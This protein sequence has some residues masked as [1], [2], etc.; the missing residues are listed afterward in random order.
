MDRGDCDVRKKRKRKNVNRILRGSAFA[1]TFSLAVFG[2]FLFQRVGF[3][4]DE[5]QEKIDLSQL[6]ET[7]TAEGVQEKMT[8]ESISDAAEASLN[9]VKNSEIFAFTEDEIDEKK[10]TEQD[11]ETK[12]TIP[13]QN[14]EVEAIVSHSEEESIAEETDQTNLSGESEKTSG[15]DFEEQGESTELEET[16]AAAA[17]H[18]LNFGESLNWPIEGNILLDYNM[19]NA[20]YFQTL[21]QYRCNPAVILEGTEG[22]SVLSAAD[23]MVKSV[24][25]SEETGVTLSVDL[26][27]G[28]EA[29]YGQLQETA[30]SEGDFISA[31]EE[32]GKIA[33]P[34]KYYSTE[35]PNLY[36]Q[37]LKDGVPTDP[38][39]YLS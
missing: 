10:K 37:I 7:E 20:V 35:G 39:A 26:G 21:Q 6:Q 3:E 33:S 30:W 19:E 32:I 14:T 23:G 13:T 34:T 8:E 17:D 2:I 1:L 18:S 5:S 24:S 36:F 22:Q 15:E 25:V 27:S 38:K 16:S 11:T 4:E 12:A 31:G 28:Y 9:N 29:V